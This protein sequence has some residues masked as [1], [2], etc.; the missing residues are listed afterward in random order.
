MLNYSW[1]K[2]IS[3]VLLR[4]KD[5]HDPCMCLHKWIFSVF[6]ITSCA[7]PKTLGRYHRGGRASCT[8][9]HFLSFPLRR[10]RVLTSPTQPSRE[11]SVRKVNQLKH[12][13]L[14]WHANM[15]LYYNIVTFYSL[16]STLNLLQGSK[17]FIRSGSSRPESIGHA[18]RFGEQVSLLGMG[19]CLTLILQ[20]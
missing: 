9:T 11:W 2:S 6:Y 4:N 14:I 20:F 17:I 19:L 10:V 8:D 13:T 16:Q 1:R 3:F 12:N 18:F 7:K 5:W 15:F